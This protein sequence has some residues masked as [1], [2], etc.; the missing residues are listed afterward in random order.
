M[1]SQFTI[2][3]SLPIAIGITSKTAATISIYI[4]LGELA[5]IPIAIGTETRNLK[6]ETVIDVSSLQ[7]GIYWIDISVG[8]KTFRAKFMKQ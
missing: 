7:K 3:N 1:N 6:P 4:V 8:E 2:H 5:V